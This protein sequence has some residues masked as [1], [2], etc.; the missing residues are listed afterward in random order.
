MCSWPVVCWFCV[1][2]GCVVLTDVRSALIGVGLVVKDDK[3]GLS[4]LDKGKVE[5]YSKQEEEIIIGILYFYLIIDS[6]VTFSRYFA[7]HCSE[8]P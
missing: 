5:C 2:F 1:D 6:P 7:C 3:S 8:V 4:I